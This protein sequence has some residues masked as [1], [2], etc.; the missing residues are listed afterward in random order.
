METYIQ[1]LVLVLRGFAFASMVLAL[2]HAVHDFRSGQHVTKYI[3]YLICLTAFLAFYDSILDYGCKMFD[4]G[5]NEARQQTYAIWDGLDS[6]LSEKAGSGGFM[7]KYFLTPLAKGFLFCCRGFHWIS[8]MVRT[9]FI[10]IYRV[11]APLA[12]G[13]AAWRVFIST[14][15]RFAAGTVWLCSWSVGCAIADIVL[16]RMWGA[17]LA[18]SILTGTEG[19]A[20]AVAAK[21]IMGGAKIAVG[22]AVL[23]ALLFALIILLITTITFYILIP[24]ALYHIICAGEVVQGTTHA[25]TG[26]I[27]AGMAANSAIYK[28]FGRSGSGSGGGSGNSSQISGSTATASSDSTGNSSGSGGFGSG[29]SSG[30]GTRSARSHAALAEAAERQLENRV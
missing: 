7:E 12:L 23:W 27:G 21:M 19:A 26:A 20:G 8:D 28:T 22:T 3:F 14:G 13:M 29:S 10:I 11:A 17:V 6:I 30:S 15:V 24:I 1:Q 2:L 9:V 16:L 25:M 5:V 18:K 4:Q